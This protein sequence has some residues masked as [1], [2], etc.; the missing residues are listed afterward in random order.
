MLDHCNPYFAHR[1]AL[2]ILMDAT[3][4]TVL[5]QEWHTAQKGGAMNLA[6]P[7]AQHVVTGTD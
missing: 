7:I 5:N 6:M 1:D 4:V 3:H 2:R